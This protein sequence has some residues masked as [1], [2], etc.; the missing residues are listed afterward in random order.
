MIC[1]GVIIVSKLLFL[2]GFCGNKE[3]DLLWFCIYNKVDECICRL[4]KF[5][6]F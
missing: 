1:V 6:N 5:K 2:L 3:F 4:K